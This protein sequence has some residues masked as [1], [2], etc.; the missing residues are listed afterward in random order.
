MKKLKVFAKVIAMVMTVLLVFQIIP[1]TL[2]SG[3][4]KDIEAVKRM[5]EAVP[6]T[7]VSQPPA[8]IM[9]ETEEKKD[10]FTKTFT[11]EDGTMVDII[12]SEPVHFYKDGEWKDIDNTLVNRTVD[13]KAVLQNKSNNFTATLPQKIE[14]DSYISIENGESK[15]S[16]KLNGVSTQ[17]DSRIMALDESLL[18]E[19][20]T[21][22]SVKDNVST[23]RYSDVLGTADVEYLVTETGIKE[24]II[25]DTVPSKGYFVSFTFT[26]PGMT[27]NVNKDKSISFFNEKSE[28]VF[29]MQAP[30]MF[31]AS[32][33]VS[34]DVEVEVY[35]SREG[36]IIKYTP[37]FEWLSDK[38]R[39]YP[40]TVDPSFTTNNRG[41]LITANAGNCDGE[42]GS[43]VYVQDFEKDGTAYNSQAL[44]NL[45]YS[46][47]Q[48]EILISSASVRLRCEPLSTGG[49][50]TN[51]IGISLANEPWAEETTS[52]IPQS[53]S[54]YLD[55]H[56]ITETGFYEFDITEAFNMWSMGLCDKNGFV[57]K[58]ILGEG[59]SCNVRVGGENGYSVN[60]PYYT[61]NYR[62]VYGIRDDFEY[63]S[64]DM[65]RAGTAYVNDVTN[66]LVVVREELGLAGNVMPAN[67]C[68]IYDSKL[69]N[70]VEYSLP[71]SNGAGTNWQ[72]NYYGRLVYS[73]EKLRYYGADGTWMYFI[74]EETLEDGT[75]KYV[76][77]DSDRF[78]L[79]VEADATSLGN[80]ENMYFE[81]EEY[82]YRFNSTGRIIKIIQKSSNA[83]IDITYIASATIGKV[84]DGVGREFRLSVQVPANSPRKTSKI[85]AYTSSGE[86]ITVTTPGSETPTNIEMTY[87]YD[88]SV[89]GVTLFKTATYAD[90]ETVRY[91]YNDNND[92]VLIENIDGSRLEIEYTNGRVSAYTKRVYD[93]VTQQYLFDE[94]VEFQMISPYEHVFTT[95]DGDESTPIYTETVYYNKDFEIERRLDSDG[96][97]SAEYYYSDGEGKASVTIENGTNLLASQTLTGATAV[98]GAKL[99]P[100]NSRPVEGVTGEQ[101]YK[102]DYSLYELKRAY[103]QIDVR[104]FTTGDNAVSFNAEVWVKAPDAAHLHG[105]RNSAV[106]MEAI[107]AEGAV[108][109]TAVYP[110][111]TAITG[112]QFMPCCITVP[113]GTEYVNFYILND[114][115]VSPLY[116][117]DI[118]F[119]KSDSSYYNDKSPDLTLNSTPSIETDYCACGTV[120]HFGNGC[121][122]ECASFEECTCVSCK[123]TSTTDYDDFGNLVFTSNSDGST[124]LSETYTYSTDNNSIASVTDSLGNTTEYD[125]DLSNGTLTEVT[126]ANDNT[127]Q[128]KYNAMLELAEV[129]KAVSGVGVDGEVG[130]V[131]NSYAYTKDKLT[132]ISTANGVNYTFDYD[133]YGNPKAIKV[134]N[135]TLASYNYATGKNNDKVT[136]ITYGNGQVIRYSYD[137]DGN[138]TAIEND[139]T[140]SGYEYVYS[141]Y[142]GE[143][144]S[145][146]DRKTGFVT[147][148]GDSSYIIRDSNNNIIYQST[149]DED[150]NYIETVNG[151]SFVYDDSDSGTFSTS[152]GE[153]SKTFTVTNDSVSLEQT[154]TADYYGRKAQTFV[155]F[156]DW[157]DGQKI[158]TDYSYSKSGTNTSN[159]L[160]SIVTTY[161][162]ENG[163]KGVLRWDYIYDDNGNLLEEDVQTD[164]YYY[165]M[166]EYDEAGQLVS[167]IGWLY[168][169]AIQY[170]TGGNVVLKEMWADNYGINESIE[171]EYDDENWPD[172]LTAVNG[173]P[174]TYD[175]IGNPLSYNGTTY[176]WTAGRQLATMSSADKSLS[177]KYNDAGLRTHKSVTENGTTKNYIYSWSEDGKLVS[178]SDGTTT[179]YFIYDNNDEIIA[180]AKLTDNSTELFYYV[181]DLHGDVTAIVDSSG[182]PVVYYK[183]D[184]WGYLITI[185]GTQASTIGVLNPIRYRGYYYD[186]ET[187][188][189]YLQSR[190]YDPLWGRFINRDVYVHADYSTVFGGN[191]F[192]Y[193]ENNPIKYTDPSGSSIWGKSIFGFINDG[194]SFLEWFNTPWHTIK[195]PWQKN[196]GYND[197]YDYSAFAVGIY[198]D[199]LISEFY[200]KDRFWRVELWKGRY[201]IT[202]GA[203][204]GFYHKVRSRFWGKPFHYDCSDIYFSME[205][206]LFQ[207]DDNNNL[208]ELIYRSDEAHWWLTGFIANKGVE[209]F[210]KGDILKPNDLVL[211]ASIDFKTNDMAKLFESNLGKKR[212]DGWYETKRVGKTVLVVW[213]DEYAEY[214]V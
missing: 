82:T 54:D 166:Y 183:Y 155:G 207:A 179:L 123:A 164:M 114:Y 24:N 149:Y 62:N 64:I 174:I 145:A 7:E 92:L 47:L 137:A 103:K 210:F 201:G 112:W 108:T 157:T 89:A 146:T 16:F 21:M 32:G 10:A 144:V 45:V 209:S 60:R 81:D 176:T 53:S 72:W 31:D 124:I 78:I 170:D 133:A 200:Y 26:A 109:V 22:M 56:T 182:I 102:L 121:L 160:S 152:T 140:H 126:D 57:L 29:T 161:Q 52:V 184:A 99:A 35:R 27:W 119:Y 116:Y 69:T 66:A 36:N 147:N 128:Y 106:M 15:V 134:G 85:G 169:A 185:S 129:S 120:C 115:Q 75:Q 153:S 162:R 3:V 171:F 213:A 122:C 43:Y 9:E 148:F 212:G 98:S 188:Y 61:V 151:F 96:D 23:V 150:R 83:S 175:A 198:I 88:T 117:A 105:D 139:S 46:R 34:E 154:D 127:I 132:S 63:H 165:Q 80:F 39:V 104:S 19:E 42:V 58:P 74:L 172:K 187:G 100:Y 214:I 17:K 55:V 203:E 181:K 68:R 33:T 156:E 130:T 2:V 14:K 135:Q 125:Y 41:F 93:T 191:V 189:Y 48:D 1:S 59:E 118:S 94:R 95:Y 168:G 158:R 6:I 211:V 4:A 71:L 167:D 180:F 178:Q 13:G 20:D 97:G 73:S 199:C 65:G 12:S 143:L 30:Y 101:V 192:A 204:I 87:T 86:Q 76:C 28:E 91:E 18:S 177:F 194:T 111:D 131:S 202:L 38:N 197:L 79:W 90:G 195:E 206:I 8:E 138:I 186:T 163:K 190:Y 50:F 51:T 113:A 40:V 159:Q 67:L 77:P 193:C 142:N 205:F 141:Y 49:D 196:F 208:T 25:L 11:R 136:T 110:I 173:V 37:S 5:A 70:S 84:T 107:N 44:L